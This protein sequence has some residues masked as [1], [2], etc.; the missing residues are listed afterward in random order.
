MARSSTNSRTTD[1]KGRITLGESFANRTM[2]IET[3][4]DEIVL[5][6]ARVIPERESW[7]YDNKDALAS[8]R[9]G[10]KEARART[11]AKKGPDLRSAAAL[12]DQLR[13]E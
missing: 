3:R 1:S 11:F 9:Q 12:A 7:L 13:D 6:L 4:G 5:R 8:V 10:L 2:L